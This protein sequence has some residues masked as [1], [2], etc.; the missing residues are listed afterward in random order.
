MIVL[1]QVLTADDLD[2]PMAEIGGNLIIDFCPLD[3][4]ALPAAG[5]ALVDAAV[6]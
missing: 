6:R 1:A 2:T 5:K 3:A 4:A